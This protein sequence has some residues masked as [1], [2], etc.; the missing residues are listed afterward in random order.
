[1]TPETAPSGEEIPPAQKKT[2]LFLQGPVAGFFPRLAASLAAEGHTALRINLNAGDRV[3]WNVGGATNYRGSFEDWPDFLVNYVEKHGVTDIMMLGEQRPYHRVAVDI[4]KARGIAVTVTDFGYLRPDWITLERFAMNAAS[5]M[6]R[7]PKELRET[8]EFLG[9]PFDH[10]NRRFHANFSSMALPDIIYNVCSQV[11]WFM[12]PHY[13]THQK[14]NAAATYI[15]MLGR[16][17][18]MK[19]RN[20]HAN[21]TINK[22]TSEAKEHPLFLLP[23][24]METDYQLRAYSQFD[25]MEEVMRCV[26]ENFS[27]NAPKQARLVVKLHPYDPAVQNFRRKCN[28]C[29]SEAGVADRVFFIDGGDADKLLEACKGTVTVNS[30]MGLQ[31]LIQNCPVYI[32]ADANYRVEGLVNFED[33]DGFWSDPGTVDRALLSD[34]LQTLI[35]CSLIRGLFYDEPGLTHAINEAKR[36]LTADKV[37]RPMSRFELDPRSVDRTDARTA[38][39]RI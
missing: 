32:L 12:Y 18:T 24:Q 2:F 38:P 21:A 27:K 29:A 5:L 17:L 31:A 13:R 15:G 10:S 20:N 14:Y 4:A 26:M 6:T 22:L 23:L 19:S 9:V 33:F 37:G 36:R 16:L 1:M 8:A 11:G 35:G 7:D 39:S 25:S 3:F 34:F 30:T 28:N